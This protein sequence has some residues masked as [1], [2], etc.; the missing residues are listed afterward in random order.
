MSNTDQNN[1]Y[2][3]ENAEL[4]YIVELMN[5]LNNLGEEKDK[6]DFITN[7][8]TLKEQIEK[9]DAILS[10]EN[11]IDEKIYHLK[12]INELFN[13]L[14]LNNEFITNPEKLEIS[15]L[16]EL[17]VITKILEEKLN[18]ETMNIIESI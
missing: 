5:K 14:E 17:L 1:I 12:N 6:N 18:V 3:N 16:K 9:T 7:Y 13:I 8:S 15:K 10:G 2:K 4:I 11:N